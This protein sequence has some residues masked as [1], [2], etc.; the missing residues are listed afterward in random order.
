MT[1]LSPGAT[2]HDRYKLEAELGKGGMGTV[3]RAK[4]LTLD[5]EVAIK[6][7]R[8]DAF[9]TE[10]QSR[11]LHEAQVIAKL[12]HPN[13]V[14]VFDVGEYEDLPYIVMQL[15][16][17]KTLKQHKPTNLDETIEVAKQIC[18]A[19]QHA[20]E[21]DIIHRD[22]KPENVILDESGTAKLMDFGLAR[23]T[24]SRMT[25]EGYIMGTVFYMSPEQAM[26][27]MLDGRSDLYSFG[28]MLYELA[29]GEFPF[30]DNNPVAIISQHLH[31]P[32]VPPRAKNEDIPPG[33]NDLILQLLEKDRDDRPSS[34]ELVL[35]ALNDPCLLDTESQPDVEVSVLD[36]IVRGRIVGRR[37][38]YKA[39]RDLWKKTT[40]GEGQTLLISGEPGI[41]KTR[42]MRE[43]TTQAE[44][45]GGWA[46]IGEAYEESNTPYGVF[47][48][49]IRKALDKR[50]QN[51]FEI[52]DFVLDDIL[53]LAPD[54]RPYYPD[55]APNPDLD[56]ESE[57]NRLFENMVTFCKTLGEKKPLLLV[58]EDAHWADSNSIA[59]F[60][61]LV[62]RT[63]KQPVML[64]ATYR[65][66]ELREA[67]PFN[68]ML[69]ELNRQRIGARLKLNRLDKENT[70]DMLAA[71]F[72][73][74]IAPEFLEGIYHETDGNPFF[75][76]ELCR[77]LIESGEM[78]F[79]DGKWHRPEDMADMQ[80]PQGI[81]V[82]VESRLNKL[83]E[84]VQETLRLAAVLG[85]EFDCEV[86]IQA[87]DQNEDA[88]IDAIEI[89]DQAQMVQEG[90]LDTLYEFVHALIPQAIRENTHRLRRRKMHNKV[91]L[92]YETI[93]PENYEALA[94]HHS[95]AGNDDKALEFFSLAGE[96]AASVHANMEVI[97]HYSSA[98]SLANQQPVNAEVQIELHRGRGQA[99][100]IM[101]MFDEALL[102]LEKVLESARDAGFLREEWRALLDLGKL[103]AARNYQKTSEYFH[104]ALAIA[105]RLEDPVA[106]G[107]SLNRLGNWH[108][109]AA[110]PQ[111][112]I[113]YH[114]EAKTIFEDLQNQRGQADTLDLLG[115]ASAMSGD[116]VASRAYYTDA[117]AQ[118][119]RL[120]DR[121]GLVSSLTTRA[122]GAP[123]YQPRYCFPAQPL[124]G[125]LSEGEQAL[126]MARE[127][128]WKA[129]E[130]Y[131]ASTLAQI[132]G[133]MGRFSEAFMQA[134][135]GLKSAIEIEH[136]QWMSLSHMVLGHLY[137]ELLNEEKAIEH[138]KDSVELARKVDSRF[139]IVSASGALASAYILADDLGQ[140]RS[141]LEEI[142]TPETP[143]S[144]FAHRKCLGAMAELALAE[145]DLSAALEIIDKLISTAASMPSD[146][147]ITTI[148]E[149]WARI[150]LAEGKPEQAESLLLTAIPNAKHF[151][152]KSLLW[153]LYGSL[154]RAYREQERWP[155]SKSAL[156]NAQEVVDELAD[157]IPEKELQARFTRRAKRYLE[158]E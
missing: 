115:M 90:H 105:R 147:V 141:C 39:A 43:V 1:S 87:S 66:V 120:D 69:Q 94:F 65:E 123:V 108:V 73:E 20:H 95:E 156:L 129:G 54:M 18:T 119:E 134:Q 111:E 126:K 84:D 154:G 98:I 71:I 146:G 153:R 113:R 104:E 128:D 130:A 17:G 99:Y 144:T 91:A 21:H 79:E 155:E 135:K 42:L 85:R 61:H 14:T 12:D 81:Q 3:Y 13:I 53:K 25:T 137:I 44:V 103:W 37:E 114:L 100:E 29:A 47:S 132:Y 70:Q 4:D 38:E 58:L 88:I 101:G 15:I 67:R 40:T 157:T 62:R 122:L 124:D 93:K 34:A 22:L 109:N 107:R 117:I 16:E 112:G 27:E 50:S 102:D 97:E 83:P 78:Y 138:L 10:G 8:K 77:A 80:I 82:A 28:V 148:W 149:I 46:L 48:Q 5:R 30:E 6:V 31:A 68:E 110:Q 116:I 24:T 145:G 51:G 41:G 106:L 151:G 32:V 89:A 49:I 74:E 96:S 63:R 33:L 86:L 140:A 64:L 59:L 152:E 26:G 9:G 11:L 139:F 121:F 92:A 45:S 75:I 35:E 143:L 52:P 19:L 72:N 131:G 118:F 142:M 36:R 55:I 60:K 133:A 56:P 136:T 76:E 2:I 125:A 7:L 23:S 150:R 158:A 127:I 57:Q